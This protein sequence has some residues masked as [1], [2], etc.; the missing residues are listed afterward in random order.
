MFHTPSIHNLKAILYLSMCA[1]ILTVICHMRS[2]VEF[3]T[4]GVMLALRDFQVFEN[5]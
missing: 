4:C 1:C 3:L 2:G 5:F